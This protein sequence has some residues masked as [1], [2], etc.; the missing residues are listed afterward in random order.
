MLDQLQWLSLN[1]LAA[2]VRLVEAWKAIHQD[3]S[4]SGLF[5]RIDSSTRA[6]SHNAVKIGLNSA[7]K[8]SSFLHPSAKLWNM[9]PPTVVNAPTESQARKGI[10]AFVKTLPM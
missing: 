10:R 2:E 8:E 6:N 5:Q 9:A 4:L 3:S 1:Q 7:I